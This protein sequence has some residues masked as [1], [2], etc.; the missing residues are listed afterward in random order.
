MLH[1][2]RST[3]WIIIY[4][5]IPLVAILHA[6]APKPLDSTAPGADVDD[7]ERKQWSL[8]TLAVQCD[9]TCQLELPS[10]N[11]FFLSAL[12]TMLPVSSVTLPE[13]LDLRV[14][15]QGGL[16][17]V[18][19][20]GAVDDFNERQVAQFL[21]RYLPVN[22]LANL[23]L[24]GPPA[25]LTDTSR[26]RAAA[27]KAAGGAIANQPELPPALTRLPAP[28][29]GSADQLAFLLWIEIVKQRLAGYQIQVSWDHRA[30]ISYVTINSTLD[31]EVLRPVLAAEFEPVLAAY[32]KA[33]NARLRSAR[34]LHRYAVTARIYH[35]P[36]SYF[37]QQPERLAAI[38]LSDIERM[39][40]AT[41]EY[42]QKTR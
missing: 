23:V 30:A 10:A 29:F 15:Q 17:V 40:E 13:G 28:T 5:T 34:Q 24:T 37:V 39:R 16:V 20:A 12:V 36:F 22:N 11:E 3:L 4:I 21:A 1:F 31:N 9:Q 42:L 32:L 7:T 38:R 19:L 14:I 6:L 2:R 8:D 33:A 35:L 25:V 27:L 18:T 41:I 26:L